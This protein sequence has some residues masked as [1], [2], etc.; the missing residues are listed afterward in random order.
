M[1]PQRPSRVAN[2]IRREISCIIQQELHD[3]RIGFVTVTRVTIT[4][5]LKQADIWVSVLGNDEQ[6]NSTFELLEAK[7]HHILELLAPKVRLRYLPHL[8]FHLDKSIEYSIHIDSLL[9]KLKKEEGW[10]QNEKDNN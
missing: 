6:R 7:N 3:P 5:D 9:T 10:E 2:L 4:K 1:I 8:N